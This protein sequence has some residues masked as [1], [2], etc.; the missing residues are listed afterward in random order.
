MALR[1][2]LFFKILLGAMGLLP[3]STM[4]ISVLSL[5]FKKQ[6]LYGKGDIYADDW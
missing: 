6:C 2:V 1:G 5:I 4:P 3:V